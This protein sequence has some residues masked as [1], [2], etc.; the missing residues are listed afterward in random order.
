MPK[1]LPAY[2]L[3]LALFCIPL[4]ADEKPAPKNII[5]ML[6][7]YNGNTDKPMAAFLVSTKEETDPAL[8]K[9]I[10]EK[11]P[12][13]E[14]TLFIRVTPD[15][16]D[17]VSKQLHEGNLKPIDDGYLASCL[18]AD[19]EADFHLEPKASVALLVAISKCNIPEFARDEL[20]GTVRRL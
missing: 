12:G 3:L 13:P 1:S 9:W 19:G 11:H 5:A 2:L 17:T 18:N 20:L 4:R 14:N 15:E 10:K 6:L 16:M 7:A 8:K